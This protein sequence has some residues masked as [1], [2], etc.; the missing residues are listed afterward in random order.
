MPTLY[1]AVEKKPNIADIKYYS[2]ESSID[3]NFIPLYQPKPEVNWF[4]TKKQEK[5][6]YCH[7]IFRSMKKN[8]EKGITTVVYDC[9]KISITPDNAIRAFD[10]NDNSI[11]LDFD[12]DEM[13]TL[14]KEGNMLKG[15][16]DGD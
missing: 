5:V 12:H 1:Q 16:L 11:M 10:R 4:P 6:T 9:L 2:S 14:I 8:R 7:E 13:K 3:D 15:W